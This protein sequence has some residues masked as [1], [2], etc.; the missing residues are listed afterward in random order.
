MK[1]NRMS[2][3]YLIA[4][5]FPA[6]V[7]GKQTLGSPLSSPDPAKDTPLEMP[8]T[9]LPEWLAFPRVPVLKTEDPVVAWMIGAMLKRQK[10]EF[11]YYGGSN[12][13]A[14]RVVSPGSIFTLDEWSPIYV[15]GYCHLRQE[16][17]VF[18]RDLIMPLEALN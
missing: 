6:G 17:R 11:V 16:E 12:A 15:A 7:E 8:A 1:M 4:S 10:I 18:R 9:E 13:G 14:R 2:F 3:L 5:L